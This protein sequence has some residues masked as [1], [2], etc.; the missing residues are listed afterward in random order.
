M[1]H[2]DIWGSNSKNWKKYCPCFNAKEEYANLQPGEPA[3]PEKYVNKPKQ[4]DP[5]ESLKPYTPWMN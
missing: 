1:G 3:Q 2:R 5:L 4:E